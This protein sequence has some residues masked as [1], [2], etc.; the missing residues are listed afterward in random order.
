MT[1]PALHSRYH[2][3][4][5][6]RAASSERFRALLTSTTNSWSEVPSVSGKA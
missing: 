5:L 2:A 6:L 1:T 4:S 3:L